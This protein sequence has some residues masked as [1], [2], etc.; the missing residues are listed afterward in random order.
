MKLIGTEAAFFVSF[1]GF[2]FLWWFGVGIYAI[3]GEVSV[4]GIPLGQDL[5]LHDQP[6][7]GEVTKQ[8]TATAKLVCRYSF[9]TRQIQ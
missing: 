9:S 3:D 6:D 5:M 8:L 4:P 7:I 2:T 1:S